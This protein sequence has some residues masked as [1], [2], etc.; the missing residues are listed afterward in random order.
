MT[1][2]IQASTPKLMGSH[3]PGNYIEEMI[4]LTLLKYLENI[5]YQKL[6]N[7]LEWANKPSHKSIATN[8]KRLL[9]AMQHWAKNQ[10]IVPSVQELKNIA[11]T[12]NFDHELFPNACLWVDSTDFPIVNSKTYPSEDFWSYKEN[13]N[14][15]RFMVLRDAKN[16]IVWISSGY[17]PKIYDSHAIDPVRLDWEVLFE[18][19][20]IF[21]DEHFAEVGHRFVNVTWHMP[22]S[23]KGRP[24]RGQAKNRALTPLK[25]KWNHKQRA[26]RAVI[27]QIFGSI[28]SQWKCFEKPFQEDLPLLDAVVHIAVAVHN[29]SI[30]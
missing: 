16:R 25:E 24:P 26:A 2:F 3:Q 10:I 14:G 15:W 20:G 23:T 19:A 1:D 4:C 13:H 29:L 27:E 8:S 21:A 11:Y 6:E 28:K 12:A 22:Y 30:K 17:S 18:G 7:L 9:L 5:G